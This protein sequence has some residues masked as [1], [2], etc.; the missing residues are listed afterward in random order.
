VCFQLVYGDHEINVPLN[1]DGH[2]E[3]RL[4]RLISQEESAHAAERSRN[5]LAGRI[6]ELIT[7]MLEGES[8]LPTEKQ[9]K[10]AVAIAREL[11]LE[12]PA[13]VLQNRE[14][15]KLFLGTYAEQYR[16]RKGL[17]RFKS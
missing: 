11:L 15:M 10:Y 3:E 12:L 1:F 5:Y 13:N 6:V 17:S 2:I 4:F 16:R 9:L 14:S 7:S 8:L